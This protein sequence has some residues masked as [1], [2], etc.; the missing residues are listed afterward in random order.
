MKGKYY[1][2]RTAMQAHSGEENSAMTFLEAR[3]QYNLTTDNLQWLGSP[4]FEHTWDRKFTDD[5]LTTLVAMKSE[6]TKV[7]TEGVVSELP[8]Q[9]DANEEARIAEWQQEL[10]KGPKYWKPPNRSKMSSDRNARYR[11]RD[12]ASKGW[13][14]TLALEDMKW[15]ARLCDI[16]LYDLTYSQSQLNR[17]SAMKESF[18]RR[19]IF[20]KERKEEEEEAIGLEK[21]NAECAKHHEA[22]LEARKVAQKERAIARRNQKDW[23]SSG[24]QASHQQFLHRC[25]GRN[26]TQPSQ[27][28]TT[29]CLD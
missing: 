13:E 12:S 15:L 22:L 24:M 19:V 9:D 27:P 17:V 11:L 26:K 1:E 20:D 3:D 10:E 18:E 2:N 28:L 14:N 5:E 25:I 23:T 6:F 7:Q 16:D 21:Y 4:A 8:A 29:G